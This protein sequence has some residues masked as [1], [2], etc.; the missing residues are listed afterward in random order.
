MKGRRVMARTRTWL[1]GFWSVL[2][3]G[4]FVGT[5]LLFTTPAFGYVNGT[6]EQIDA[7]SPRDEVVAINREGGIVVQSKDYQQPGDPVTISVVLPGSTTVF[8]LA[9]YLNSDIGDLQLNDRNEVAWYVHF[10]GGIGELLLATEIGTE[11]EIIQLSAPGGARF[12]L[13]NRG[14][15]AWM[16]GD[17]L[18]GDTLLQLR[19]PQDG[20]VS[21]VATSDFTFGSLDMSENQIVWSQRT[22]GGQYPAHLDYD[23]HIYTLDSGETTTITARS[24]SDQFLGSNPYSVELNEPV[25]NDAGVAAWRTRYVERVLEPFDLYFYGIHS[26]S[27]ITQEITRVSYGAPGPVEELMVSL[28]GD[29]AWVRRD[30]DGTYVGG[31]ELY[32]HLLDR[33][34]HVYV[35]GQEE[36]ALKLSDNQDDVEDWRIDLNDRGELVWWVQDDAT[37]SWRNMYFSSELY[38]EDPFIQT[39]VVV[40]SDLVIY[41]PKINNEGWIVWSADDGNDREIYLLEDALGFEPIQQ[42]TDHRSWEDVYDDTGVVISDDGYLA[43]TGRMGANADAFRFPGAPDTTPPVLSLP[44][45]IYS[46]ASGPAWSDCSQINPNYLGTGDGCD[47]APDGSF[48]CDPDCTID[49]NDGGAWCGCEY[50]YDE[51][52]VAAVYYSASASDD[53]D[54]SVSVWCSPWSG[55]SFGI[56]QTTVNCDAEDSAGNEAF[57]SFDVFVVQENEE[58]VIGSLEVVEVPASL[59]DWVTLTGTF[60][61]PDTAGSGHTQDANIDWGDGGDLS[62]GTII[63]LEPSEECDAPRQVIAEHLYASTGVYTVTMTVIDERGLSDSAEFRYAV[64]FDAS[65]AFVTGGGWIDSPEGA[66]TDD[67]LLAGKANFGFVSKYKKGANVPTGNTEFQF[68]VADLNFKSTSYDWLVIAGTKAK[69]KG[70][71]MINGDGNYGFMLSA[72]DGDPKGD[73]DTFRIKIWDKDEADVVV[74][75]NQMGESDESDATTALGGGSIVI[76]KAK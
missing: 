44:E 71:G 3:L 7:G 69:F 52:S 43:W 62:P 5:S 20:S 48:D 53:V 63:P 15:V 40:E 75:D 2:A 74:Y 31:T 33:E 27:P 76:H 45:D 66:Y 64:I 46:I 32:E 57:G 47:C 60:C 30:W 58:P 65:D 18:T 23:L 59:G 14:Y 38:R 16:E 1:R 34:V 24:V 13:N 68:K 21:T 72:V 25:I 73:D 22:V 70:D 19:D 61:D 55:H 56:G 49:G 26:Y 4:M 50:C 51:T 10:G 54:G 11:I 6:I 35:H 17:P 9:Q 12:A 36:L 39:F 67:L 29:V 28:Q 8:E 42:I 41:A 37:Y